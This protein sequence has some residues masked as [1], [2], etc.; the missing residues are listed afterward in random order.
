[1]DIKR[2]SGGQDS[3]FERINVILESCVTNNITFVNSNYGI[4]KYNSSREAGKQ[5]KLRHLEFR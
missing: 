3:S 2:A 4:G 5:K 1:L